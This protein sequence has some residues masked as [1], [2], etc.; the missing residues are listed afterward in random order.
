MNNLTGKVL[1]NRYILLEKI[2]DGG[3]ALV[4][5]A[6]C[7]LL[8]RYVAVKILRPE[9]IQDEE[10]VKKFK[11]ESLA[12]ASLS[13]PN[14]VSI[15]DVGQEDDIYYIVMEYVKGCTLKEYIKDKG[16][17]NYVETLNIV[18][19]IA[20]ALEH[21]HK[22]GV[23]HRD[24]KPHNILMTEDGN[25]KVT[26]FGIARATSSTTVTNMGKVM[27]SVHYFSPEQARG[28]YTDHR[29]DIYSLGI[30]MYEML[31]GKLPF[32]ADSPITIA[33]KHI[34]EP[35]IEP[36]SIDPTIPKA[37][38]D[39][40]VKAMEKD[41]N[42]RYQSARDMIEDIDKAKKNPDKNL[43][44]KE[45]KDSEDG[46]TRVIPVEE[47]NDALDK[48]QPNGKKQ[49]NKNN[50]KKKVTAIVSSLIIVAALI[51]LISYWYKNYFV[52]KDINIPKIIGYNETEANKILEDNKLHMNILQRKNSDKPVGEVI[53]VEP[54]E[55]S[56]VKENSTV[57]VTLSSGKE[58]VLVPDVRSRN[59]ADA[60]KMLKDYNLTLGNVGSRN[61]NDVEKD[62]I[63][64]QS[65]A[66]DVEVPVGSKV[67]IIISSGPEVKLVDVPTLT[68]KT[69]EE[70]EN[71]IKTANLTLGP[72]KFESNPNYKDGV[73][74]EQDV[75]PKIKVPQ[76]TTINIKV[77]KLDKKNDD[78]TNT[79][80]DN[81]DQSK[82]QNK[83][84]SKDQNKDKSKDKSNDKDR[85]K[86]NN[87]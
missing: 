36:R 70:A 14:I 22:N 30:V 4:Y 16:K 53:E 35:Y 84:Q 51:S 66:K 58:K 39:I 77:N 26:D 74:I 41:I 64:D 80:S 38:N 25:V 71:L 79:N 12:V 46:S 61:S 83:D 52:V 60:E 31:T 45:N 6:R 21:A 37:V 9:Y 29:T 69:L 10:F 67:D 54:A 85:D 7:Q 2:G 11:R 81:K 40:V 76:G 49:P 3:M 19:Q 63:I 18:R 32:D 42:K 50:K 82:D 23:I 78:T 65:P 55:G 56:T 87:G 8:N 48:R 47:I 27:G 86:N 62:L 59:R 44:L 5:K 73:V 34:Q 72:V 68:D 13:H 24:I 75:A 1:G 17:I 28:G 20:L 57:N 15:Y 43:Y 33:L